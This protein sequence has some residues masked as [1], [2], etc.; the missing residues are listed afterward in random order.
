[1]RQ[2]FVPRR[3]EDEDDDIVVP[4]GWA[5]MAKDH[6][7][8]FLPK[9]YAQLEAE[10]KL[11]ETAERAAYLTADSMQEAMEDGYSEPEAWEACRKEFIFLA[12][13]LDTDVL[14][15]D[16]RPI[17][18]ALTAAC[19]Y[20]YEDGVTKFEDW[21]KC[22]QEDIVEEFE[23]YLEEAWQA[24]TGSAP[25]SPRRLSWKH[26][27]SVAINLFNVWV[28]Q[29]EL[30]WAREAWRHL[31]AKGLTSYRNEL[32]RAMVLVR[33]G[34][35]AF[36]YREFCDVAFQ[37][38]SGQ[39][40]FVEWYELGID[41]SLLTQLVATG[42]E[43]AESDEDKADESDSNKDHLQELT[44]RVRLE[45]YEALKDGFGSDSMLFASLWRSPNEDEP[46]RQESLDETLNCVTS[47]KAEAFSWICEGM[48]QL[49]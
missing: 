24:V 41:T 21:A 3:E 10:G 17:I 8:V 22:V 44:V 32:D 23:P 18:Q 36:M 47:E 38:G 6:W 49:H 27:R 15:L 45:I 16:A 37:E 29:P 9:M 48:N 39:F 34:T 42:K 46:L 1:M 35:L 14:N 7:R 20:S 4:E 19:E 43:P 13:E 12:S 33:L 30:K 25:I 31:R 40:D 5:Q 2:T 26:V 11:D 28:G